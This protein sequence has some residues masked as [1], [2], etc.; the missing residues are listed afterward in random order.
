MS[1]L[2]PEYKRDKGESSGSN[3]LY[4]VEARYNFSKPVQIC[5]QLFDQRWLRV[6]FLTHDGIG[7]PKLRSWSE[8]ANVDG[9]HQYVE[10]QALR[11]WFHAEA[12]KENNG[13]CLETR[14]IKHELK[15]KQTVT[16]VS[17]HCKISGE[18]RSNMIPDWGT[19]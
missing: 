11:W 4:T 10:A 15:W 3:T 9:M 12:E 7:V 16:A 14:L 2:E 1:D 8:L 13:F 18:D 5:G 19:K 6:K 17:Q